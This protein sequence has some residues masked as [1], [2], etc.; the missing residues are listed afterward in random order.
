M[1][2]I[3]DRGGAAENRPPHGTIALAVVVND[4]LFALCHHTGDDAADVKPAFRVAKRRISSRKL[5]EFV[6]IP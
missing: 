1:C 2:P 5:V 4:V 6:A 3:G